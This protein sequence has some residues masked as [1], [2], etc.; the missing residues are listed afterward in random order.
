MDKLR[1]GVLGCSRHYELR[2]ALPLRSSL[3]VEPYAVASRNEAKAKEFADK[4]DFPK[5]YG[6]YGD[7]L[8]DPAVDFVYI[9][10]PN[11]L[12]LEYIKKT[13]DAGK[14][15]LCEKPIC[16][17]AKEAA[18]AAAYCQS[19]N[20]PLMEA[21]MYRF[22]PQW[23]RAKEIVVA[24]EIGELLA[25]HGHFSYSNKD[26]NNIRNRADAGGGAIYDIGC[27]TASS[28]RYLF[29]REPA[30]VTSTLIRDPSFKT[31]ILVSAILDFGEGRTA[32][33]TIGTQ[34]HPGQRVDAVGSDGSLSI[35]V[36]FN[37]YP[38]VPGKVTVSTG[39]GR[40]LIETEIADQYL[41]E[42]DAYAGSI[43]QQRE[44][45]TPV[46]DAI[47]NMAVLD[48]LFKSAASGAWETVQKY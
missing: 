32:T 48:A 8:A 31:D 33:F 40:R 37:M 47:A 46:S 14:P 27:Y 26:G 24:G 45:P 38:D 1:M 6:A 2:V 20:V 35:E 17:N 34:M 22:H 36:P 42:F 5:A 4:L 21:F 12:H 7:L 43:I 19:R 15:V 28:A 13:A 30:R 3:L 29:G 18:E 23:V 44:A 25:V 41:L 16:L 39:V 11:H 9:P 10:L